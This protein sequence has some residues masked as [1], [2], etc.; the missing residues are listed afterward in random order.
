MLDTNNAEQS[1]PVETQPELV[2]TAPAENPQ[3]AHERAM[4]MKYVQDQGQKI[5]SNFKSAEDWFNSLLQ[6]RK[7]FTQ[8]RQEIAS[9][10]KQYNENGTNNPNYVGD[11]SQ[12]VPAQPEPVEDLSGIPEDL[13]ITPPPTPQPGS[14][15]KVSSEDWLRWGKEI[16]SSGAVSAATR[17]EIQAKM[18]ADDVIIEQMIQGR[19]A[20]AK[21]SWEDAASVVGG[22]DNLKRLFKWAQEAKSAD[23]VSAINRSLQIKGAYKNVLLGLK[24]EYEQTQPQAKPRVQEPQAMSNRVNPSQVPQAVQVFK[25]LAEQKAAIGDP[26]YRTDPNFRRAVEQMIVN[27]SKYGYRNR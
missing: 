1:Q 15:P 9:L 27:T 7:G 25:S 20:L 13:K 26:R 4:F 2:N 19:R 5:P 17:K 23:E 16:D 6:A 21:Q 3:D 18:G 10:K 24:A 14:T 8:A 12:S 22:S 11:S